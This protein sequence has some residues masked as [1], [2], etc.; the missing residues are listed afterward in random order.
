MQNKEPTIFMIAGELSGDQYGKQLIEVLKQAQP[1]LHFEGVGGPNMRCL[2]FNDLIEMEKFEVMGFSEVLQALPRLSLYSSR[3]TKHILKT[4]PKCV[5]FIDFPDFN[6]HVAKKLRAK[7]YKGTLIHFICPSVWAWRKGRIKQLAKTLDLLISI[8]PFEK[9]YFRKSSL[10]VEYIGN[11]LFEKIQEWKTIHNLDTSKKYVSLFPGSRAG[12]IKRNLPT[13]LAA[14]EKLLHE[15]PH[16]N[17]ALSIAKDSVYP[18]IQQFLKQCSSQ[19]KSALSYFFPHQTYSLMSQSIVAL[20]TSGTVTLELALFHVPTVMM[21]IMSSSN[22][23]IAKNL[24]KLI[25]PNYCLAN[26]I[27]EKSVF[28]EFIQKMATPENIFASL[29]NLLNISE[30]QKC[31]K[32]CHTIEDRLRSS[33]ALKQ[34]ANLILELL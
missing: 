17:F 18:L 4:S 31:I 21:Y 29:S 32:E 14:A 13:Q 26:I 3:L 33:H 1:K 19:L 25:L 30:H 6:M 22:Y 20:A 12:E 2:G 28:P 27:A 24:V 23:F 16:L 15:N 5:I 9:E 11:P 34:A 10:R 7:G 8:F